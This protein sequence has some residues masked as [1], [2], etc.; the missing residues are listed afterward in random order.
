MNYGTSSLARGL[1]GATEYILRRGNLFIHDIIKRARVEKIK[2]SV[3]FDFESYHCT[4]FNF[5]RFHQR[6]H[7]AYYEVRNGSL[8]HAPRFG[9]LL[10]VIPDS[11]PIPC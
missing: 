2:K 4:S 3:D 9:L 7:H 10:I 1:R 8:I 11:I 5:A 6:T